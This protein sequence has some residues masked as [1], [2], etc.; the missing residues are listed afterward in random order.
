MLKLI[1]FILFI[2]L[3]TI[4]SSQICQYTLKYSICAHHLANETETNCDV[5]KHELSVS[6]DENSLMAVIDKLGS[7][8]KSGLIVQLSKD[9][10]WS[11]STNEDLSGK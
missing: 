3:Q 6:E 2:F 1:I 7:E 5:R 11:L 10:D 8:S 4:S 9:E